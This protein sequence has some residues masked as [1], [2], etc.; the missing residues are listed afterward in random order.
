MVLA[1]AGVVPLAGG[2]P[3]VTLEA[4]PDHCASQAGDAYC[5]EV[6]PDAPYCTTGMGECSLG[7]RFGCVSDSPPECRQPCGALSEEDCEDMGSSSGSSGTGSGSETETGSSDGATTGPLPCV[8]NE[9]CTDTAAPYCNPTDGECVTCDLLDDPDGACATNNGAQPLCVGGECVACTADDATACTGATPVCEAET[10]TCVPCTEHSQC[11]EAACNLFS[12][13]C[14][15]SDAVVRVGPGQEYGTIDAAVSSFAEGALG[16]IIVFADDYN[17]QPVTV[18]GGRVLAFLAAELGPKVE[19]PRWTQGGGGA[20]QLRV[21][22]GTV[23]LDGLQLSG[24]ASSMDPGVLVNGGRAWLDRSRI[25]DNNGGGAVAQNAGELVLR[26]CFVGSPIDT[27]TVDLQGSTATL[28]Y[29]SLGASLGASTALACDG[30]ST[31]TVRNSLVVSRDA[32][33]EITCSG[34][35]VS[36]TAAEAM[37]AG[38]GNEALGDMATTWF[39]DYNGGDLHLTTAPVVITNTARWQD[40]D[41]STD[42]DGQPRPMANGAMDVAGAD[43]P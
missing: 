39:A 18:D 12:G 14:L 37:L 11:G 36:Y 29:S 8:M 10:N 7:G 20:P 16:T 21:D 42:I 1:A 15:P 34:A 24:N 5:A 27:T 31:V 28:L 25:V 40:G 13:Q 41:P 9:D 19:P 4:N 33:P 17:N 35:T 32:T 22:D 2:C 30:A 38:T 26:N 6:S 3:V 23:L 43:V